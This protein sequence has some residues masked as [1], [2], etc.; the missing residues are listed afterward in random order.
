M[1]QWH[2]QPGSIDWR[3]IAEEVVRGLRAD[4]GR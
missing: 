2:W 4:G 3:S 1:V